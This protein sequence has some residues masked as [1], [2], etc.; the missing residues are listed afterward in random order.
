MQHPDYQT[1]PIPAPTTGVIRRGNDVTHALPATAAQ[2]ARNIDL[3]S[4]AFRSIWG[5]TR[6]L[7]T[8]MSGEAR[9]IHAQANAIFF[10]TGGSIYRL[11]FSTGGA[12]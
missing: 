4:G 10:Q 11:G 6:L 5:T 8:L 1:L 3:R 12:Y 2:D 9:L 7:Q